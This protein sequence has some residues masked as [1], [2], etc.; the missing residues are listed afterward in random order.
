MTYL[1]SLCSAKETCDVTV[2]NLVEIH[3]CQRDFMSYL[4]ASFQCIE[5]TQTL[6]LFNYDYLIFVYE[7]IIESKRSDCIKIMSDA[8][9]ARALYV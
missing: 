4:E 8:K 9:N 5:G 7:I 3:P 2:R 6:L 1:D